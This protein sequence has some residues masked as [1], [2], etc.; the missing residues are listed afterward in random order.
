MLSSLAGPSDR[1]RR[2]IIATRF[3]ASRPDQF[4][5]KRPGQHPDRNPVRQPPVRRQ[6]L[7]TIISHK[8]VALPHYALRQG[9]WASGQALGNQEILISSPQLPYRLVNW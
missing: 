9:H 3:K 7:S 4:R 6:T 5:R 1:L 2:V 8:T